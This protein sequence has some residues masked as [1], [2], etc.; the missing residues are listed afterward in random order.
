MGTSI[1]FEV[2]NIL[3]LHKVSNLGILRNVR[4]A[5]KDE[6]VWSNTI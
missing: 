1:D 5:I 3:P 2:S 4:G 6:R